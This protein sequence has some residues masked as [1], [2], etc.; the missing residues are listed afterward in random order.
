M[1]EDQ[2]IGHI[3]NEYF[4]PEKSDIDVKDYDVIVMMMIVKIF[5]PRGHGPP[6]WDIWDGE[7]ED[8]KNIWGKG[9]SD[10]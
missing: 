3:R 5:G 9:T 6:I 8:S 10:L 7:D 1:S 4:K 2:A